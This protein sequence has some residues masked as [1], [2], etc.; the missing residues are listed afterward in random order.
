MACSSAA[1]GSCSL[2]CFT[3][4]SARYTKLA[5]TLFWPSR[6]TRLINLATC[7]LLY[8]GS[9]STCLILAFLSLAISFS[10]SLL[11]SI[12]RP[13]GRPLLHSGGIVFAPDDGVLN[14]RQIFHPPRSN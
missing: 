1:S 14:S 9:G 11:G 10:L 12:Q 8:L 7:R 4:S 13:A 5:A 2:F 6:I 3:T